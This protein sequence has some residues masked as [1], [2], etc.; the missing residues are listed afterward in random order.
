MGE[1]LQLAN[2]LGGDIFLGCV[3]L[4]FATGLARAGLAALSQMVGVPMAVKNFWKDTFIAGLCLLSAVVVFKALHT[5][6]MAKV[7]TV[8]KVL[9]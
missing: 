6:I 9:N 8:F 7:E 2:D 3:L 4:F 5:I 1:L